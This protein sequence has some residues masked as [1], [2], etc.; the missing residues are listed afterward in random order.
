MDINK[1][2]GVLTIAISGVEWSNKF[3]HFRNA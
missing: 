2:T 1:K 3:M